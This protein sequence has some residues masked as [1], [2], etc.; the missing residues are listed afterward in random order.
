M[1]FLD[2][3]GVEQDELLEPF[4]FRN[5]FMTGFMAFMVKAFLLRF[6]FNAFLTSDKGLLVFVLK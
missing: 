4:F 5:P 3:I 6:S 2:F 1:A